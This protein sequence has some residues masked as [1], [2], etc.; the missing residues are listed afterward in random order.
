M[1]GQSTGNDAK[2]AQ[3]FPSF[4][5]I[6]D[7]QI[8]LPFALHA[9]MSAVYIASQI[10]LDREDTLFDKIHINTIAIH[11]SRICGGLE[12]IANLLSAKKYLLSF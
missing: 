6:S 9:F 5:C 1:F 12:D 7:L 8:Y 11:I 3:L 4:I 2:V 10:E